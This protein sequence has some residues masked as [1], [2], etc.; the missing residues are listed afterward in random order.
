[1]SSSNPIQHI[2]QANHTQSSGYRPDIDGLRAIAVLCVVGFH[3]FP[4]SVKGGFI[5][6]DI[7]FVISGYLITSIIASDLQNETF[8]FS[9][10]YRRRINRIFPALTLVLIASLLIGYFV[11]LPS[12]LKNLGKQVAGGVTF[13]S[14]FMFWQESGYFDQAAETKP[15]LHLWS[16]AIEEQFYIIWPIA[17]WLLRNHAGRWLILVTTICLA[18]FCLNLWLINSDPSATFYSPLTRFWELALGAMLALVRPKQQQDDERSGRS[19]Q[20]RNI[21]AACGLAAITIGLVFISKVTPFPG[22]WALLPT[23]GCV[24][25]IAAGQQAWIN[26]FILSSKPLVWIGLISYPL[27]LWHWPLLSFARIIA[28]QTPPVSM[29]VVAVF[30]SITLAWITYRLLERPIRYAARPRKFS[31]MLAISMASVGLL[32]LYAYQQNGI[33]TTNPAVEVLTKI[34]E[35]STDFASN[36]VCRARYPQFKGDYCYQSHPGSPDI[37]VLGDSHGN[38]LIAGLSQLTDKNILQLSHHSCPQFFGLASHVL[39]QTDVCVRFTQQALAVALSTPSIK[40]ILIKFRGP[41]YIGSHGSAVSLSTTPPIRDVGDAFRISMRKTFD[42]LLAANKQIIFILDNPELDFDPKTCVDTRTSMLAKLASNDL[43]AIP[44]SKFDAHQRPYRTLMTEVLKNYPNIHVIDSATDL[45][46][47]Q[48]CYGKKNG[49]LL[50][51]DLDHLSVSGSM[52]IANQI[53]KLLP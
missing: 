43:C 51:T 45:C 3:A 23:L 42:E 36:T 35:Q 11:L 49:E 40:T 44:K 46:D 28:G 22:A 9:N 12:E 33:L 25:I 4:N 21:L 16:L 26:R 39:S 38:R 18:S 2:P 17:L 53:K 15:L 5:G 48:H 19:K 37:Q 47:E 20:L 24:M 1:M 31:L 30:L 6:V 29:R 10:F 13:I 27:Y 8:S 14:N 7:F 41:L 34:Q 52:L 32:G 50:Y